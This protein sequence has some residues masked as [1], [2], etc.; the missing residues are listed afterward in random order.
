MTDNLRWATSIVSVCCLSLHLAMATG[1]GPAR[2]T[3]TM[4]LPSLAPTEVFLVNQANRNLTF[5]LRTNGGRWTSFD[6]DSG[7]DELYTCDK[8][9][10]FEFRMSTDGGK[11]VHYKLVSMGRYV[12]LWNEPEMIWDLN[13]IRR[14]Q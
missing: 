9:D 6:L 13:E 12:L 5:Q 2:A 1:I 3:E 11:T 14:D 10:G 7:E 8:C 4:R